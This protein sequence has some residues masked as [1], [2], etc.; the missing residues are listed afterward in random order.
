MYSRSGIDAEILKA[1]GGGAD[2]VA[3]AAEADRLS[4][5][6]DDELAAAHALLVQGHSDPFLLSAFDATAAAMV[7]YMKNASDLTGMLTTDPAA[8]PAHL[9]AMSA[10]AVDLEQ[11]QFEFGLR[12]SRRRPPRPVPPTA[13]VDS[14]Y[15]RS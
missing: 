15:T 14:A 13:P 2:P 4:H 12:R 11:R 10:A 6:V 3:V 9:V 8:V 5:Q 1:A 7:A